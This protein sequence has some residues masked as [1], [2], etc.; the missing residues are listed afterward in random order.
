MKKNIQLLK[1]IIPLNFTWFWN[2]IW[3]VYY[4]KIT[5]FSGIALIEGIMIPLGLFLE[6]PTGAVSDIF[7]KKRT[8]ILA[9]FLNAI[10]SLSLAFVNSPLQLLFSVMFTV[11][12]SAFYSGTS[13]A[14]LY[15]SLNSIGD[16]KSFT[17]ILS[18]I[19]STSLITI[20]VSSIIGGILY[21]I[22]IQ[23]PWFIRG[24]FLLIGVFFCVLLKEP[25]I[26]SVKFSFKNFINQNKQGFIQIFK[27]NSNREL[28][29]KL[30][31][32]LSF[33]EFLTELVGSAFPLE[34]GYTPNQLG[35]LYAVIP[36]VSAL[37]AFFY[38]Y[39]RNKLGSQNSLILMVASIILVTL[40]SP[41][42]TFLTGTLAILYRSFFS[43]N[44]D[45]ISSDMINNEVDS[46][47]RTTTLSTFNL[48][49]NLPYAVSIIFIGRWLDNSYASHVSFYLSILFI[50]L[51]LFLTIITKRHKLFKKIKE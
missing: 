37:G 17:K 21:S 11:I 25:P 9:F 10:A 51:F 34:L 3:L 7:G 41:W 40:I 48:I 14:I 42:L 32:I 43:P 36:L 18:R 35:I 46:K 26:D 27:M 24:F 23:Y 33:V 15:D 30:L 16:T 12:A 31:L 8:L 49:K 1:F 45:T 2:G 6:I 19:R 29:I 22:N 20:A 28:I 50:I 39:F 4:L 47:Y 5:N 44:L 13:D 38:P